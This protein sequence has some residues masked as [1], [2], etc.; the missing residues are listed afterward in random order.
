MESKPNLPQPK[1][2]Y[3][4]HQSFSEASH[5]KHHI[6]I[7]VWIALV[8]ASL[9][10][11]INGYLYF[12]RLF[13][14]QQ[15]IQEHQKGEQIIEDINGLRL[16]GSF[17][18]EPDNCYIIDDSIFRSVSK[19]SENSPP[20][21]VVQGYRFLTFKHDQYDQF[22]SEYSDVHEVGTYLCRENQIQI[23]IDQPVSKPTTLAGYYI[24]SKILI[25]EG[26]E[27]KKYEDISTSSTLPT[28][29]WQTYRNEE[30]GFELKYPEDWPIGEK[31]DS[32]EPIIYYFGGLCNSDAFS[33]GR[34]EISGVGNYNDLL[35]KYKNYI[36]E[37]DVVGEASVLV[38][39]VLAK[40]FFW[41]T[42][43]EGS[44]YPWSNAKYQ[45]IIF[46]NNTNSFVLFSQEY[47][48]DN[49]NTFQIFDQILST[50]RFLD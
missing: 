39:D 31:C 38:D 15:G 27:Y 32:W 44:Y 49:E 3:P 47:K 24:D 35:A 4:L 36:S 19:Y 13:Y 22:E 41:T 33:P 50:F 5:S 8:V 20:V 23:H 2:S 18:S 25:W 37:S 30:Y 21:G 40:K 34:I 26:I 14:L 28:A 10:V 7:Y 43:E 17:K 6:K 12:L 11:A 1:Q 45:F 48:D 42:S 16:A 9:F 29:D 46:K